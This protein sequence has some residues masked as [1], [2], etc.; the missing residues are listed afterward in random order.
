MTQLDPSA[1]YRA[2]RSKDARF[3]GRFF[4]GVR[5]TGIYCRPVCPAKTPLKANCV[6][7]RCAAEAEEAG[8]RPCL[9][10]RPETAPGTPAWAGTSATVARA[11]RLI[12]EGCLAD[13]DVE[14]LAARVGVGSRQLR[15]LFRDVL[16]ATPRA[17]ERSRRLHLAKVL[18]DQSELPIEQIAV[19]S[20]Y[21]SGRRLRAAFVG[22]YGRR[23]SEMRSKQRRPSGNARQEPSTQARLSLRLNYRPPLDW[24]GL[25]AFLEARTIPAVESWKAGVYRRNVR[26]GGVV[27]WIEARH[28][29]KL[30][31][32]RVELPAELAPHV[33]DA[34]ARIRA[35]FDLDADPSAIHAAL[36]TDPRLRASLKRHPGLRVPGCWSRFELA[37]RAILGQQVTVKGARTLAVRLVEKYGEPV[38]DPA[39]DG[40]P[41][42]LFPEPKRLAEAELESIG[43]IRSR[44]GAI[45]ELS[46]AVDSGDLLLRSDAGLETTVREI[47]KLRGIG[48]W[49]AQYI[50][51]RAL[52]EPD[53]FPASDLAILRRLAPDPERRPT[54]AEAI[55][56]AEG[57][58]PWRAYATMA[59]WMEEIE[60]GETT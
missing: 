2:Q 54:H 27:G 26:L 20:G 12:H 41:T 45:R 18:L 32:V 15:R 8:F 58:R 23:P 49:T 53:A 22:A 1:C 51:M 60:C 40:G 52:R 29:E 5:T 59:L 11:F 47:C 48:E 44:A 7:F 31:C 56:A 4:T 14:G 9:R 19:S 6:Y 16:G 55:Q 17:V 33:A 3:D 36:E 25:R 38:C 21:G 34:V 10:C 42:H 50:A 35:L 28:D 57:W 43:L 24:R 37:V 13:D 30:Q 39:P 46:K